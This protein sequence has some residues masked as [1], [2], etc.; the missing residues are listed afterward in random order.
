MFGISMELPVETSFKQVVRSNQMPERCEW[1][2]SSGTR[3]QPNE[4]HGCRYSNSSLTFIINCETTV[5]RQTS[6]I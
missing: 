1:K 4:E 2:T 6:V 3:M 5:N